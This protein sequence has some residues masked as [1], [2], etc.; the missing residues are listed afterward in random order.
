MEYEGLTRDDLE[1][2][3]ALNSAWLAVESGGLASGEPIPARR[4]RRLAMTPFLLFTM[5]EHDDDWWEWLLD[6]TRQE[7]LF[8]RTQAPSRAIY[9]LQTAA[10]AFLWGLSRCNPYVA[11]LVSGAPPRS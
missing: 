9:S 5:R 3:R 7:D 2:V 10:L 8:A 6:D 11:R 1:N 4:L